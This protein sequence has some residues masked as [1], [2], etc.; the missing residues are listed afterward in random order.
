MPSNSSMRH[1]PS[2]QP[3]PRRI[4]NHCPNWKTNFVE[5]IVAI[6]WPTFMDTDRVFWNTVN[7]L[8]HWFTP[9]KHIVIMQVHGV[10]Y[11]FPIEQVSAMILHKNSLKYA[12]GQMNLLMQGYLMLNSMNPM[13]FHRV[14][15]HLVEN[16]LFLGRVWERPCRWATAHQTEFVLTLF[17]CWITANMVSFPS[18]LII[19][20][21]DL[22]LIPWSAHNLSDIFLLLDSFSRW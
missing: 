10:R 11:K 7:P 16:Q 2:T 15:V 22:I 6:A 12:L 18:I 13:L 21:T 8:C 14:F 4:I 9:D 5:L 20:C 17:D 3:L 19:L 1:S